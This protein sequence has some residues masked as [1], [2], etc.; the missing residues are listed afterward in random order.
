ME[1]F[2]HRAAGC[3]VEVV[4]RV[5]E[6]E[7]VCRLEEVEVSAIGLQAVGWR[8]WRSSAVGLQAVGCR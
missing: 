4:C 8:R 3:R 7:V 5:E 1:V 6:V 2:S